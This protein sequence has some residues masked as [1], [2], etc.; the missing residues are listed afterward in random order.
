MGLASGSACDPSSTGGSL[1]SNCLVTADSA[2]RAFVLTQGMPF[3]SSPGA[4]AGVVAATGAL[5]ASTPIGIYALTVTVCAGASQ[6]WTGSSCAPQRCLR[7][8]P[9]G[10]NEGANGGVCQCLPGFYRPSGACV[11]CPRDGDYYCPGRDLRVAC[12]GGLQTSVANAYMYSQ[13]LC[14]ATGTY[15]SPSLGGCTGCSASGTSYCPD[16]WNSVQCPNHADA[17]AMSTSLGIATPAYCVCLEGYYGPGCLPC[18]AGM[19]CTRNAEFT[20]VARLFTVVTSQP[21]LSDTDARALS[22]AVAAALQ[23]YY[24]SGSAVSLVTFPAASQYSHSYMYNVSHSASIYYTYRIM[25]L[26]QQTSRDMTWVDVLKAYAGF[27]S[28]TGGAVASLDT[29][30]SYQP[31]Y[32]PVQAS[33]PRPCGSLQVPAPSAAQCKCAPGAYMQTPW[34]LLACAPCGSMTFQSD[35]NTAIACVSC[36]DGWGTGELTGA[37]NCTVPTVVSPDKAEGG[38]LSMPAIVGIAVVAVVA[39]GVVFMAVCAPSAP[40]PTTLPYTIQRKR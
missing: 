38:G 2:E 14:R 7:A 31:A 22:A 1:T 18:P 32:A 30:P 9:C 37:A 15:F 28:A 10:T 19:V 33:T 35:A 20:N 3:G 16:K 6:Y 13:C 17:S 27:A 29:D 5:V 24:A 11:G 21:T 12:G 34:P 40:D 26:V 8:T 39:C 23:T 4:I 25:V 36:P